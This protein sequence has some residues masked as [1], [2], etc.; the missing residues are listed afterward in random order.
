MT[1]EKIIKALRIC[2]YTSNCGDC[3]YNTEYRQPCKY[4]LCA[5]ALELIERQRGEIDKRE[6]EKQEML[7]IIGEVKEHIARA[8]IHSNAI[9]S[10]CT[11]KTEEEK[12]CVKD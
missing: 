9:A 2:A 12:Q 6:A 3:P 11:E 7:R 10:L 8:K 1:D 5:D 4:K